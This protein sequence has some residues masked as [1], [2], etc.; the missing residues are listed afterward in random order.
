MNELFADLKNTRYKKCLIISLVEIPWVDKI[1]N[2][3]SKGVLKL[4]AYYGT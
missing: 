3:E 4:D 1:Q 2:T